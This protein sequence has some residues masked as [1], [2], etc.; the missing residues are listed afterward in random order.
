M[1]KSSIARDMLIAIAVTLMVTGAMTLSLLEFNIIPDIVNSMVRQEVRHLAAIL[2][3]EVEEAAPKDYD[4]II[5]ELAPVGDGNVVTI[6]AVDDHG[7]RRAATTVKDASGKLITGSYLDAASPAYPKVMRGE[8]F[9]GEVT[10]Y[11]KTY[12][13][14]YIPIVR[15]A[16]VTGAVFVGVSAADAH[17]TNAIAS[18]SIWTILIGGTLITAIAVALLWIA[19]RKL[20]TA[21][22]HGLHKA[23]D[24]LNSGEGDLTA[25]IE[26]KRDDELGAVS[27]S[28]NRFIATLRKLVAGVKANATALDEA[29]QGLRDVV[30]AV[31]DKITAQHDSLAQAAAGI[32]QMSVSTSLV[33]DQCE[34]ANT[35]TANCK[36]AAIDGDAA[37]QSL[38]TNVD[39]ATATMEEVKQQTVKFTAAVHDIVVKAESVRDIANQTNLLAL[40]AAIEAAR[41]GEHGRGFAVVADE[42]RKLSTNSKDIADQITA[43]TR[44]L[45]EA[46]ARISNAITSES[47]SMIAINVGMDG[48]SGEFSNIKS[49]VAAVSSAIADISATMAE[50][51]SAT[52]AIAT[53]MERLSQ[54]SESNLERVKHVEE[55]SRVVASVSET[56]TTNIG[57]F[58]T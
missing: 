36:D 5:Q 21:R 26:V 30:A 33:A 2:Q 4:T 32:Q 3:G 45:S 1:K 50:Q 23:V 43:A 41:A 15:G 24:A 27:S 12:Q 25:S 55:I 48:V 56:L 57:S 13:S 39:S 31:S 17:E 7:L 49:Q 14:H 44:F 34:H 11:G 20:I 53:S 9:S 35:S 37:V 29:A 47:E 19:Q 10:I 58:R 22:L 51:N 46:T 54:S 6:F 38:K 28:A 42:V 40:N 16:E 8:K 18:R 52:Q